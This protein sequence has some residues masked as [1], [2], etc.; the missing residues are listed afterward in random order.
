MR[1]EAIKE[2]ERGARRRHLFQRGPT[3]A[4]VQIGRTLVENVLPHRDPFLFVDTITAID[5]EE[6]AIAG[7]RTIA[8]DDPV[9]VGHFPGDPIYPGVLQLETMGQLGICL[10]AFLERA[11]TTPPMTPSGLSVRALRVHSALFLAPLLPGETID[12]QARLLAQNDYTSVTAGQL[13]KSDGTIAAF[14]V[15]E[16]YHVE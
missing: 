10:T 12:I 13:H 9:F 3:T 16:A 7:Q 11:T 4:L 1:P 14:A 5:L 15:I 6:Q 2:I 8:A